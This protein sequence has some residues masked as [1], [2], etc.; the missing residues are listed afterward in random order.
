[1][2]FQVVKLGEFCYIIGGCRA[3]RENTNYDEDYEDSR[4]P[5]VNVSAKVF[6]YDVK[7]NHWE[8]L[9]SMPIGRYNHSC[10]VYE[11]K[12][13]VIGGQDGQNKLVKPVEMYDPG[14]N[15]WST[16]GEMKWSRIHFASALYLD[17]IWLIGGIKK[18]DVGPTS[19]V[20]SFNLEILKS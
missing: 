17:T 19:V 11:K 6:R 9:E 8:N 16:I 5:E 10:F 20:E 7:E 3:Y 2:A 15:S 14:S 4:A 18:I 1:M 12:I 13:I